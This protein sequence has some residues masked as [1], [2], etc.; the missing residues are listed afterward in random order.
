[1]FRGN[2]IGLQQKSKLQTLI[3]VSVLSVF[4][5]GCT[6]QDAEKPVA[7]LSAGA[8]KSVLIAQVAE[9]SL[10][11]DEVAEVLT[12]DTSTDLLDPRG[13]TQI[14]ALTNRQLAQSATSDAVAAAGEDEEDEDLFSDYGEED[15]LGYDP[16]DV[17]PF[18][19]FNRLMWALNTTID[20]FLYRPAAVTWRDLAPDLLRS[21][22]NNFVNNLYEPWT[23]VNNVLQGDVDG[24]GDTMG[25]F[26]TNTALGFGFFNPAEGM[27]L[28][29]TY[30]DFGQTLGHYGAGPGAYLMLP[31]IGPSTVR[32]GA[33]ILVSF[34]G[35]PYNYISKNSQFYFTLGRAGLFGLNW[36]VQNLETQDE[37][38]RDAIDDYARFRSLYLQFRESLIRNDEKRSGETPYFQAE[39][40]TLQQSEIIHK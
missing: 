9:T 26:L 36:R 34:Y 18:E 24:A 29:Y 15:G 1:M 25:R 33:G 5:T 17:D 38:S 3:S 40:E 11:K 8:N 39:D 23:L 13:P 28:P 10:T 4:V 6:L 32:D 22:V 37:I 27:G 14:S 21:S 20:T 30:E 31:I 12:S 16:A 2:N 7:H 19:G 35:D